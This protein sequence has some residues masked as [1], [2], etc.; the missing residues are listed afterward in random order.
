ML[1]DSGFAVRRRG[2]AWPTFENIS[3]HQPRWMRPLAGALRAF[4]SLCEHLP[5]LRALGVVAAA[6]GAKGEVS[7]VKQAVLRHYDAKYAGDATRS[8]AP[9]LTASDAPT[10]R[11]Q[12]CVCASCRSA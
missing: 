1:R 3:G 8:D 10:D 2:F 6:G 9:V 11:Y 5:A 12:A 4:A 7:G